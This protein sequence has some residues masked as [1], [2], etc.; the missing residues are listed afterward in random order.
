MENSFSLKTNSAA[1]RFF[2]PTDLEALK[3]LEYEAKMLQM[4][5]EVSALN[6]LYFMHKSD[7]SLCVNDLKKLAILN[8]LITVNTIDNNCFGIGSVNFEEFLHDLISGKDIGD[9]LSLILEEGMNEIFLL[10]QITSFVQQLFMISSYAR[11]IGQPNPKEILGFIPPKNI[12][13]KKSKL[14]INIKPYIFQEILDYL[15]SIELELKS[16]KID[17]QSVYLQSSLRKLT[18]LFR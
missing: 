15:L 10:N 2:S 16:S 7:L 9:D 3:F 13:E 5:Y 8:E 4:K 17:N 18:V 6:H 1:V 12:W 11:T 14:A